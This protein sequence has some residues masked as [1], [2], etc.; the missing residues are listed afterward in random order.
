MDKNDN[1]QVTTPATVESPSST[2]ESNQ[3]RNDSMG[4]EGL[5]FAGRYFSHVI[6][7]L[8]FSFLSTYVLIII[9][10]LPAEVVRRVNALRN[11]QYEHHKI[12][13]SFFE[14]V[15]ALECRYLAKYQPLYEKVFSIDKK[16]LFENLVFF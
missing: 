11:I 5:F 8:F 4:D 9:S 12:E 14:E 7:F 15:H 16:Y 6:L 3:Q 2:V 13:A 1:E 10:S